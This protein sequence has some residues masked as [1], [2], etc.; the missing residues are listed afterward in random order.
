MW[1]LL[2]ELKVKREVIMLSA[3]YFRNSQELKEGSIPLLNL[4]SFRDGI[5]AG[6]EKRGR[7][8]TIEKQQFLSQTS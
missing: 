8:T 5:M 2:I 6:P 1:R 4:K 7:C 3:A